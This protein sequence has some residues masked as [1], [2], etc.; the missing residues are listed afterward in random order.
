LSQLLPTD[1]GLAAKAESQKRDAAM[2]LDLAK[3]LLESNEDKAKERL[4]EMLWKFPNTPAA[5]EAQRL[6]DD[7]DE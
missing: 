1:P 3:K 5:E 7:L 2:H 4:Q 6:L